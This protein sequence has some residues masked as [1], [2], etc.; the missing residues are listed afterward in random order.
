MSLRCGFHVRPSSMQESSFTSFWEKL[1][2][3]RD[4][5]QMDWSTQVVRM[6]QAFIRAAQSIET[7]VPELAMIEDISVGGA[8]SSLGARV[9]TTLA[10]GV[11][12]GPGIVFYHGGG[13]VLGDIE[14]FDTICKR[15][16]DASRSRVLSVGYRLAPEHKFPAQVDDA[17]ASFKWAVENAESWGADPERIAVG[18]DSAGGNLC[19]N[20]TRAASKGDC[21]MPAFQLLVYPLTQFVDIKE[22]GI[23]L[24]EG[25]FLS[26]ALFEFFRSAYLHEGQ[27]RMDPRISPL[28][29]QEF[30][31]LPPAHIIT[32]GWDPLRDEGKAYAAKLAAAGVK[33]TERDYAGQPHGFFNTTS[34]SMPA[35]Q[36]IVDAGEIVGRALGAL[37]T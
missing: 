30:N 25:P 26:T 32:A 12:P 18:G 16:A 31:G 37:R 8:E 4:A 36:A 6:R 35:R 17:V 14:S 20:I 13:F 33:V 24:Q 27:D 19:I 29:I 7:D 28:F 34:V 10:A 3:K 11:P 1:G 2:I 21:P 23:K 22:K 15:L 9:Y 5:I